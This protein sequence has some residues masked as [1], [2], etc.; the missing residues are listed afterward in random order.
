MERSVREN[1][2]DLFVSVLTPM[3]DLFFATNRPNYA[4]WMSKYQ[5]DIINC[6]KT[7]PG[8]RALL[9]SG[10][11]SIR[12]TGNEFSSLPVDLTLEQTVNCDA[13]SRKTGFNSSSNNYDSRLRWSVNKSARAVI[14][15]EALKMVGLDH[16]YERVAELMRIF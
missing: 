13:A 8:L 2:I 6:D 14:V 1:N 15:N 9:D 4:R 16:A 10:G 3:T 5:L 11:F 12:R 7:H